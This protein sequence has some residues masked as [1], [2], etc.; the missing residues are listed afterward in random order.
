MFFLICI[1]I[2]FSV[3]MPLIAAITVDKKNTLELGDRENGITEAQLEAHQRAVCVFNTEKQLHRKYICATLRANGHQHPKTTEFSPVYDHV[4]FFN[5]CPRAKWARYSFTMVSW[6]MH[7][8]A[9]ERRTGFATLWQWAAIPNTISSS[10]L[11]G[12]PVYETQRKHIPIAG[13]RVRYLTDVKIIKP[14]ISGPRGPVWWLV[15]S[16][17]HTVDKCDV[18]GPVHQ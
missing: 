9:E 8:Q 7:I 16:D 5:W 13:E 14:Y 4:A 1:V 10:A 3:V 11:E 18:G 2:A 17:I 6:Y 15:V 12:R